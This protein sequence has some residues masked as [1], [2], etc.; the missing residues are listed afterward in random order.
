MLHGGPPGAERSDADGIRFA[1]H[2]LQVYKLL[3][4]SFPGD[5]LAKFPLLSHQWP[6]VEKFRYRG[7]GHHGRLTQQQQQQPHAGVARIWMGA[8]AGH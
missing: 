3:H 4:T 2:C 8:W 1:C 5:M 7:A 6:L